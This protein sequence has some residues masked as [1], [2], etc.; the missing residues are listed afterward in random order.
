MRIE[1][2]PS[3]ACAS[4]TIPAATAA[5]EPPLE[6]PGARCRCHGLRVI[7]YKR[8]SVIGDKPNSGELVLPMITRPALR[9]RATT[10]LSALAMLPA[11]SREA[12]VVALPATEAT[13]LARGAGVISLD[14][15]AARYFA[16]VG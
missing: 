1:P 13:L 4:G 3:V 9:M 10:S 8:D 6:P 2:P 16:K 5:A 7:P 12:A 11:S 14:H 15:I